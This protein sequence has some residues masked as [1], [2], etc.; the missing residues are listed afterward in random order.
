MQHDDVKDLAARLSPLLAGGSADLADLGIGRDTLLALGFDVLGERVKLPESAERLDDRLIRQQLDRR[1][2]RW[3]TDLEV[4]QVVGS[5][6]TLLNEIAAVRSVHGV[7][8]LAELQLQGRGRRGRGWVSPYANNLALSLGARVPQPTE[9]LGGLSLCIGLAV[10]DRLKTLDVPE[11]SLKW[12]N[13]VLVAGRKIA[14]IL[15]ELHRA[16]SGS[17]IVVGVG[18]NFRL[19]PEARTAIGQPVTDLEEVHGR[20]SRNLVAAG[21]ISSLVDYIDAFA[22][23]GFGP[24][25]E[26]FNGIH[27]YHGR[28]CALLLGNETVMGRVAGVSDRGEL[29]L[30][31][32][33]RVRSFNAGE[34]SLRPV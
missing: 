2:D 5:T 28:D 13:D 15:I 8:R 34:V 3:L 21:L 20:P 11:V 14:G 29:L 7:V 9:Q 23:A 6:S 18:V 1:A 33:G 30:E 17:E 22:Q 26:A 19:P 27:H 12:P 31:V 10:A 16:G 4:L 24:M 32:D 25:A